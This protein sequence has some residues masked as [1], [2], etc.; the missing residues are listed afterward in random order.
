MGDF[1][2]ILQRQDTLGGDDTQSQEIKDFAECITA[3][4]LVEMRSV[5]KYYSWTNKGRNRKRLWPRIDRALTNLE[6]Y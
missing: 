4:E 3:C 1:D 5:G 6:C 2:T